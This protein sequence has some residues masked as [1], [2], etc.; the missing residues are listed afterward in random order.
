MIT[1]TDK[2]IEKAISRIEK[3]TEAKYEKF[4]EDFGAKQPE[5]FG[6]ILAYSDEI[7]SDAARDEFIFI[8]SV[9]WDCYNGLKLGLDPVQKRDITRLEK[10]QL[11]EWEKLNAIKD[12]EEDEAFVVKFITQPALWAFM[13]ETAIPDPKKPNKT[14]FSADEDFAI[15]Y[16]TTKLVCSLLD[17]KVKKAE[18]KN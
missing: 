7:Q 1:I 2:Q 11:K 14:N 5:L 3:M 17:E 13:T 10:V 18:L 4:F 12:P 9:I 15:L 8:M 6:Y 16:S